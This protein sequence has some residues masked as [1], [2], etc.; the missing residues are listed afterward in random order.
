MNGAGGQFDSFRVGLKT[1]TGWFFP[2]LFY[3]CIM[4]LEIVPSFTQCDNKLDEADHSR[5]MGG[6]G[7]VCLFESPL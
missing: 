4:W 1:F 3:H 5:F 7:L 6:G 2:R